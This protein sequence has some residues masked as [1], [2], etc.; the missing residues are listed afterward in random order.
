MRG[1]F[2][3]ILLTACSP[4]DLFDKANSPFI[5]GDTSLIPLIN[6]ADNDID[7]DSSPDGTVFVFSSDRLNSQYDIFSATA[8]DGVPTG[9]P[10]ALSGLNHPGSADVDP[11]FSPDG[12]YIFFSSARPGGRGELDIYYAR[13]SNGS[14]TAVKSLGSPVNSSLNESDPHLI[15]FEGSLYLFFDR[16]DNPDSGSAVIDESLTSSRN[17]EDAFILYTSLSF[18]GGTFTPSSALNL[19]TGD[20]LADTAYSPTVAIRTNFG[21]ASLYLIFASDRSGS[22]VTTPLDYSSR[23]TVWQKNG[24]VVSPLSISSN[25]AGS[26]AR[27]GESDIWQSRLRLP[28]AERS[29]PLG[30]LVNSR[31]TEG[32]PSLHRG[33]RLFYFDRESQGS[34]D[35]F[36]GRAD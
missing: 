5:I 15:S 6:T 2:L 31:Y 30:T 28:V 21:V 9:A 4:N 11:T 10:A 8:L 27:A 25:I 29:V 20:T 3:L 36:Y 16:D 22:S 32:N 14:A 7:P 33:L 13:Y 35:I 1:C 17:S 34:R 26:F 19:V 23:L 24:G 12:L 18:A